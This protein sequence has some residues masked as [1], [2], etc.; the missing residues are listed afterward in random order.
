M[1][2]LQQIRAEQEAHYAQLELA[3]QAELK[4]EHEFEL[5]EAQR[6]EIKTLNPVQKSAKKTKLDSTISRDHR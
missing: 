2:I 1:A 5:F 4:E 3:E 6:Q